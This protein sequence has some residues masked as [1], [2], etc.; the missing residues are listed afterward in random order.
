MSCRN[1][2]KIHAER[3]S[4]YTKAVKDAFLD[5]FPTATVHVSQMSAQDYRATMGHPGSVNP[6]WKY[7]VASVTIPT[8]YGVQKC[9]LTVPFDAQWISR[10]I[11]LCKLYRSACRQAQSLRE[12]MNI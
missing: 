3:S 8:K 7:H 6:D 10:K 5:V 9:I 11:H 2:Y 1:K 4:D 12:G